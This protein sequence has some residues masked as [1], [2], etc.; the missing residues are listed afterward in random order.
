MD[1]KASHSEGSFRAIMFLHE[2]TF[3]STDIAGM[4]KM[5]KFG[6]IF[7][8]LSS[9]NSSKLTLTS[10]WRKTILLTSTSPLFW[11]MQKWTRPISS[12]LD[13]ALGQ[14]LICVPYF[15]KTLFKRFP[16]IF[17]WIKL[18]VVATEK[19]EHKTQKLIMNS[20]SYSTLF[21]HIVL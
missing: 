19:C 13:F 4:K 7:C 15:L 18:H 2:Q 14:W 1:W 21:F 6:V 12:H 9:R 16:L 20:I 8:N 17:L 11:K 3:Y 10:I 5:S